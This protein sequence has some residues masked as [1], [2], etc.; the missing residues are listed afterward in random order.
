MHSRQL[1]C[2]FL[3]EVDIFH[4]TNI[5]LFV[6]FALNFDKRT[7][8]SIRSVLQCIKQQQIIPDSDDSLTRE[9]SNFLRFYLLCQTIATESVRLYFTR[10]VPEL[11]L[12]S[13][14]ISS[15]KDL[16]SKWKCTKDQFS[17]LFPGNCHYKMQVWI[18][19]SDL[20]VMT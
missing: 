3:Y 13:H 12:A 5:T 16:Q 17:V 18:K 1:I 10:K 14:L 20:N 4:I 15:K 9:E 7:L 19:L 11:S 2:I 6:C 8:L